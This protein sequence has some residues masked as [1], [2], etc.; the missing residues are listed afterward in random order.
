MPTATPQSIG[1]ALADLGRA[2]APPTEAGAPATSREAILA[3]LESAA[4]PLGIDDIR[5]ATGLHPNTVRTHLDVLHAAGHVARVRETPRGPG[6]PRWRYGATPSP[7]SRHGDL[8]ADLLDQLADVASPTLTREA[9]ERWATAAGTAPPEPYPTADD[10]VH[11]VARAL[12]ELGF[13]TRV[14]AVGDRIELR[15]CPYAPLVAQRPVIC[16]IHAELV[17]RLLDGSDQP[18]AL[19]RLDVWTRPGLCVAHVRRA[20]VVPE[21]SIPGRPPASAPAEADAARDHPV[22]DRAPAGPPSESPRR[23]PR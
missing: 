18:V 8:A 15:A 16:D 5:L 17:A 22:D 2:P 6:R 9:A 10:A 11:G 23:L 14:D 13:E 20:D 19:D 3:L 4:E 1:E 21:R 12:A 7:R